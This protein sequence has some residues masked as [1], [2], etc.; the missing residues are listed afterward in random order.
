MSLHVLK[1]H[2]W[3]LSNSCTRQLYRLTLPLPSAKRQRTLVSWSST[4]TSPRVSNI[5]AVGTYE[6]LKGSR[7]KKRIFYGQGDPKSCPPPPLR[8]AVLC[9]FFWGVH[10][11][12]VFDYTWFEINFDKKMIFDPLYD[13][14]VVWR[15]A[16]QMEA[17]TTTEPRMQWREV[18]YICI[19]KP[20]HH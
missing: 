5:T 11:T 4:T 17:N 14:L 6:T 18:H 3:L 2:C 19:F 9:F 20:L 16:F 13:L 10:L 1:L 7:K 8:S 12:S 15:W